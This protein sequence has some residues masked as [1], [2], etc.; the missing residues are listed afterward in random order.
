M[1][2]AQEKTDPR[3]YLFGIGSVV[4]VHIVV[5][6]ALLNGLA[7]KVVEVFKKPLEVAIIEEVKLQQ[8]PPPPKVLRPQP[9]PAP[10]PAYVPPPEVAVATTS[11]SNAVTAV[12]QVPPPPP[13][14]VVETP[15]PAVVAVG[16]VCPNH[17]EV[18]SRV[19]YPTQAIRLGLSG[20]VEVEFSVSPTGGVGEISVARSTNKVF[21]S[22]ATVAVAQLHCAGHGQTVRVRVPFV[23]RLDA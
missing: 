2:Y 5:I 9:R 20:E 17:A 8:P 4:L 12:T 18:R 23:F 11:P 13:A 14:P 1:S 15:R 3:R 6:Y 10:P 21:N 7:R 19:P 16:V 22:A